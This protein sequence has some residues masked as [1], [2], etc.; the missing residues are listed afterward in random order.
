M[1]DDS[2]QHSYL[3]SAES[4]HC[5]YNPKSKRETDNRVTQIIWQNTKWKL[6]IVLT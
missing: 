1:L 3:S 2:S 4:T 5:S 6:M